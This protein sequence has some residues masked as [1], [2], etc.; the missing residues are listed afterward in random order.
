M[1]MIRWSWSNHRSAVIGS[2][3][4]PNQASGGGEPSASPDE[5]T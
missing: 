3:S 5:S 4:A 2:P 1:P